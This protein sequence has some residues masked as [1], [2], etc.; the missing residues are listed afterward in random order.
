MGDTTFLWHSNAGLSVHTA[1]ISAT[2]FFKDFQ[3]DTFLFKK[4]IMARNNTAYKARNR[5]GRP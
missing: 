1:P 3:V 5:A 4:Y 2:L